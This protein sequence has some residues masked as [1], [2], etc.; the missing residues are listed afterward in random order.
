MK[1]AGGVATSSKLFDGARRHVGGTE[2]LNGQVRSSGDVRV[3]G[4]SSTAAVDGPSS[5]RAHRSHDRP[6]AASMSQS[7]SEL[8][9]V[10]VE[11]GVV[12][13]R[14]TADDDPLGRRL[15]SGGAGRTDDRP[16]SVGTLDSTPAGRC[17]SESRLDKAV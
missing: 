8:A 10:G 16:K 3:A 4:S 17:A 11:T 15:V 5:R 9:A 2:R 7:A 13:Q 1:Q 6:T 12:G 14:R